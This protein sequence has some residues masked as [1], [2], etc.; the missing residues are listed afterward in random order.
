MAADARSERLADAGPGWQ[1]VLI[2]FE[3]VVCFAA[4]FVLLCGGL[5]YLPIMAAALVGGAYG[6]ALP[7]LVVATVVLGWIGIAGIAR[8]VW[9][10]CVRRPSRLRRALTLA[11]LACGVVDVVIWW[12]IIVGRTPVDWVWLTGVVLVPLASTAHLVFLAR[13]SLFG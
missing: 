10:I 5:M 8:V 11:A 12:I 4:P 1:R 9:V 6:N 13:R 7:W 3:A 2:V